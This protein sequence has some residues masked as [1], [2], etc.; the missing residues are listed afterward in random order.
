MSRRK[1]ARQRAKASYRL[2]RTLV[3]SLE[4]RLLLSGT[5]EQDLLN[6]IDSA[7][8]SSNSSGLGAW[9]SKLDDASALGKNLPLIGTTLS[10]LNLNAGLA[11]QSTESSLSALVSDIQSA[12]NNAIVSASRDLPDDI[13]IDFQ[14]TVTKSVSGPLAASFGLPLTLPG[15]VNAS[16]SFTMKLTAGAYWDSDTNTPVFYIDSSDTQLTATVTA[17]ATLNSTGA[18]LGFVTLGISSPTASINGQFS[19]TLNAQPPV[20]STEQ[21]GRL[22][23]GQL[24]ST[25]I[26]SLVNTSLSSTAPS[27]L[28][29]G[30]TTPLA[31]GAHNI[32]FTWPDITNPT[33]V[34]SSL[35]TDPTLAAL[36]NL[37]NVSAGS[38][39]SGIDQ[40]TGALESLATTSISNLGIFQ[41][42][43][44]LLNESIASVVNF[45]QFFSGNFSSLTDEVPNASGIL[46]SP[47]QNSDQLL[48]LLKTIPNSVVSDAASGNQIIYT[49]SFNK[50]ISTSVPLS[51]NLGSELNLNVTSTL[52]FSVGVAVNVQFGVDG[53]TG[54][55]LHRGEQSTGR[56]AHTEPD[57]N[58]QRQRVAGIHQHQHQQRHGQAAAARERSR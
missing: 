39:S 52:N 13:E 33:D 43:L 22:T 55:F 45:Q 2:Y 26:S 40:L 4:N 34:T 30:I 36:S 47:F 44:P 29:F 11:L 3:E 6:A 31:S 20:D 10:N 8:Q 56:H 37:Q 38:F 54:K 1:S 50:N 57:G 42:K 16:V 24:T 14:K 51:L 35:T 46:A 23:L 12:G 32:T 18:S 7:L 48:S 53:S 25:P 49:L 58:G 15:T 41:K 21:A 9:T 27:T 5:H 17:T 28:T 19:M